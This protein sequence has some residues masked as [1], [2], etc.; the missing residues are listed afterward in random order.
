MFLLLPQEFAVKAYNIKLELMP[1]TLNRKGFKLTADAY[2]NIFVP[3]KRAEIYE[4]VLKR[5]TV[6]SPMLKIDDFTIG[7]YQG[8]PV[9]SP[10][11]AFKYLFVLLWLELVILVLD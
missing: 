4:I 9:A 10:G 8:P 6:K 11:K 7:L 5:L 2:V 1:T 3:A